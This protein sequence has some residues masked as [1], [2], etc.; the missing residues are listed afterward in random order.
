MATSGSKALFLMVSSGA[1][2][3]SCAIKGRERYHVGLTETA[4]HFKRE[5]GLMRVVDAA[6]HRPGCR[7]TERYRTYST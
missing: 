2:R 7:K 4:A 6:I 5:S 1:D 3:F